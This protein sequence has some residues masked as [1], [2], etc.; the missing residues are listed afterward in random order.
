M[1]AEAQVRKIKCPHCGFIRTVP[2]SVLE[3]ESLG[4]AVRGG[5]SDALHGAAERIR[6]A[7]SDPALD[8]ANAWIDLPPCGHCHQPY[9]YNA[10]T[11]EVRP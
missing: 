4:S 7:L 9:Q 10:R 5:L 3:D 6:A 2:V 1:P 11:G 8:Q